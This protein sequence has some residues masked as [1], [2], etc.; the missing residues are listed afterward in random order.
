VKSI[1]ELMNDA[2]QGDETVDEPPPDGAEDAEPDGQE[3]E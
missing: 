1:Q 2:R 3:T